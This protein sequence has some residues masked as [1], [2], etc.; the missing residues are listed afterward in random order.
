MADFTTRDPRHPDFWDERFN[1]NFTPWDKGAVPHDLQRFV[2]AAAR[3]LAC[4]IP[5]C[6]NGYEA[7]YLAQAGWPVV[8]IDFSPAAVQSAKAAIGEWGKYVLEADFF[9]YQPGQMLDLIYERAF[10]CALPPEIRPAIVMRWAALL[11]AGATLA[12]YFFFDDTDGASKKGPPF[13]IHSAEFAK[14]MFP[15]FELL[16]EHAVSDSLPVFAGK[17]YWQVWQRKAV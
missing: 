4:L 6:G 9:T 5:G 17:E 15:F 14:L 1:R 2:E 10:F 13:T 3:P 16:E 7:A 12:G 8:A 11:P